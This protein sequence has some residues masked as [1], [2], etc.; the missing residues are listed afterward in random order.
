M[1]DPIKKYVLLAM[2]A[3]MMFITYK[4]S[5]FHIPQPQELTTLTGTV[6]YITEIRKKRHQKWHIIITIEH[7]KVFQELISY[8]PS[9][10]NQLNAGEKITVGVY[11]KDYANELWTLQ[12]ETGLVLYIA[13]SVDSRLK[14]RGYD[15]FLGYAVCIIFFIAVL[16]NKVRLDE[17]N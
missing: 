15:H 9:L 6:K 4:T 17:R 5:N 12:S 7:N 14:A 1:S 8:H 2:A 3:F 13:D 16:T 10:L 11:R